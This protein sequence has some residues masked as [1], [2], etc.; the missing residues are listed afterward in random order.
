M[1]LRR[2]HQVNKNRVFVVVVFSSAFILRPGEFS[3][4]C[5]LLQASRLRV[6]VD[7]YTA[8][9]ILMPKSIVLRCYAHNYVHHDFQ[10][11]KFQRKALQITFTQH[12]RIFF[13]DILTCRQQRRISDRINKKK[14]KKEWFEIQEIFCN[15]FCVVLEKLRVKQRIELL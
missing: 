10:D 15:M 6:T 4:V 5:P 13:T 3:G 14:K 9:S 7:V 1:L 8:L 11:V 2:H 12:G